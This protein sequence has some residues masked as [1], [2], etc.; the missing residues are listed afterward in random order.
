MSQ[1]KTEATPYMKSV[2]YFLVSKTIN[3]EFGFVGELVTS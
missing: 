3:L 2:R 1:F